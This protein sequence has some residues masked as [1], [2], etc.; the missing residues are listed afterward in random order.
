MCCATVHLGGKIT[1]SATAVPALSKTCHSQIVSV[2]PKDGQHV[3]LSSLEQA[4]ACMQLL[5]AV[6][7]GE[8]LTNRAETETK[9]QALGK[10]I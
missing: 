4:E 10:A 3:V 7:D 2:K 8:L 9:R 1:K 5:H 6:V